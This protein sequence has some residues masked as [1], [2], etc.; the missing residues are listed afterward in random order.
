MAFLG[1]KNIGEKIKQ[2][3]PV[4]DFWI[5]ALSILKRACLTQVRSSRKKQNW[6]HKLGAG[7]WGTCC[8][9]EYKHRCLCP[10]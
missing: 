2:L 6:C 7:G 3:D 5:V 9:G 8:R 1:E 10:V 4:Q